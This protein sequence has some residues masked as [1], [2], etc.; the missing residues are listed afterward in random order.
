M[1]KRRKIFV[2]RFA[3][4]FL[5]QE[6]AV[7]YPDGKCRGNNMEKGGKQNPKIGFKPPEQRRKLCAPQFATVLRLLIDLP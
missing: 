4:V 6:S 3:T 5:P 7:F 1:T 2:L